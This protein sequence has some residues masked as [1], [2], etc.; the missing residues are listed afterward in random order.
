M[1][2]AIIEA[3]GRQLWVQPGHFYDLNHICGDPGD[4][5]HLNRV[6]FYCKNQAIQIGQPCLNNIYVKT[7]ILKHLRGRKV[8]VFKMKSKKNVRIKNGHRQNMTR[9]LVEKIF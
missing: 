1:S 7:K 6:L 4:I 9:L 3:S 5:V 2:Y 8:T